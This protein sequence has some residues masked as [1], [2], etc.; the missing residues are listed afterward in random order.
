MSTPVTR[1]PRRASHAPKYAVPQP[2]SITSFPDTSPRTPS[3][4]SLGPNIPHVISS[5]AQASRA[6]ASV[7]SAFAFVQL[8]RFASRYSVKP[9]CDLTRRRLRRVRAVDEIV[10]HRKREVATD[11]SGAGVG[12]VGRAHRRADG[13]DRPLPLQHERQGR[14]RSDELDEL[15]VEGLLRVFRVVL[16]GERPVDGEQAR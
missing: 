10:R 4:E 7:Y 8:S 11:R 15:G 12:W 3:S 6:R 2:S 14:P 9:E 13:R 1:A 5:D 16:L